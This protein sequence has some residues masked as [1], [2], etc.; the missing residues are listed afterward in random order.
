VRFGLL[1]A[2]QLKITEQEA[3]ALA[4]AKPDQT[5][6]M[7]LGKHG[8]DRRSKT[9]KGNQACNARLKYGTVPYFRAR[10]ERDAPAVFE[11]LERGEFKSVRAAAIEAG[12]VKPE[13]PETKLRKA[14]ARAPEG[15]EP[16]FCGDLDIL[17]ET[18][19]Q[20]CQTPWCVIVAVLEHKLE[21]ARGQH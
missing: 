5:V 4:T 19:R 3:D 18:H 8:G 15:Q 11:A 12:I 9:A 14:A 10:L 6:G 16:S 7:V 20:R 1:C 21:W 13:T 17:V 2:K